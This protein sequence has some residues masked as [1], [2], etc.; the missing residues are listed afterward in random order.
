MARKV[1]RWSHILM[2][3]FEENSVWPI[4]L[5]ADCGRMVA[6]PSLARSAMDA[7]EKALGASLVRV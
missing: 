5:K 1:P 3:R 7:T 4:R 2:V 6:K